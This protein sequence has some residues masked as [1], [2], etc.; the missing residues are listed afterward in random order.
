MEGNDA[1]EQAR[2]FQSQFQSVVEQFLNG[3]AVETRHVML[4]EAEKQLMKEIKDWLTPL[5]FEKQ[6]NDCYKRLTPGTGGEFLENETIKSWM[7][8]DSD[9]K[10]VF[11][12]GPRKSRYL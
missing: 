1:K 3:I 5:D 8:G 2:D 6:F 10:H 4:S 11:C 12:E 7:T 9:I